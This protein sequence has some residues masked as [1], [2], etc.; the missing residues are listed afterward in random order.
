MILGRDF[1]VAE[2]LTLDFIQNAYRM[3]MET[4]LRP[5]TGDAIDTMMSDILL[6][7]HLVLEYYWQTSN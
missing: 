7:F 2:Q 5:F 6:V 3:G 1:N 4:R